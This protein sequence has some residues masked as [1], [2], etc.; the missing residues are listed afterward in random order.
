MDLPT[1]VHIAK[2]LIPGY[3]LHKRTGIRESIA[4]PNL[5]AS[6]RIID[7]IIRD[8][9]FLDFVS[10]LIRYEEEGIMGRRITIAYLREILKEVYS[11]GYLFDKDQRMFVEDPRI[12]KTRNWGVLRP[13]NEYTLC[14]LRID[15]AGN[16]KLVKNNSA[17]TVHRAYSALRETVN[18]SVE[19]R[20]GRVWMWEGDGGVAAFFFG[21][22]NQAAALAAM[23]IL[24]ELF[25]YNKT[26]C[27]MASPLTVRIGVHSGMCEYTEDN[28]S[29]VKSETLQR[30]ADIEKFHTQPGHCSISI[31]VR[32]MLD[33]LVSSQFRPVRNENITCYTYSLELES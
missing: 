13:G 3:D 14:F 11:Q 10:Y 25:L 21:N 5:D 9:R 26:S 24:H 17:D 31:V 16:T 33:H 32:E 29:L 7:D 28:A 22:R 12:R 4:I 8:D 27:P 2:D 30:I 19:R 23:E 20:N 15:I 6:R 18:A 1:M